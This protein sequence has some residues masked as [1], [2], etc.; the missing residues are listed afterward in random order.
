MLPAHLLRVIRRLMR[1]GRIWVIITRL[2]LRFEKKDRGQKQYQPAEDPK[3]RRNSG[4]FVDVHDAE[5][6]GPY[7]QEKKQPKEA[8][9]HAVA[10]S[11]IFL[12]SHLLGQ[13]IKLRQRTTI[14]HDLGNDI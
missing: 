4:Q 3:D 9:D 8:E 11:K 2:S 7:Q 12:F 13:H 10:T 14:G 1:H 5:E 6:G